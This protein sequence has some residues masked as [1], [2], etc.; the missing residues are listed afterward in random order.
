[1]PNLET[2]AIEQRYNEE[3]KQLQANYDKALAEW[4]AGFQRGLQRVLMKMIS[5]A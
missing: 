1:M 2:A 5:L 4:Q 3:G